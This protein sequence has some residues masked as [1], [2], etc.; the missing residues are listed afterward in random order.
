ML[1]NIQNK[2]WTGEIHPS[3]N[4]DHITSYK[5]LV[6]GY[7]WRRKLEKIIYNFILYDWI[8]YFFF[9]YKTKS[10]SLMNGS[11]YDFEYFLSTKMCIFFIFFWGNQPKCVYRL[12]NTFFNVRS[13]VSLSKFKVLIVNNHGPFGYLILYELDVET[14]ATNSTEPNQN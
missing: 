13:R 9:R 8:K 7:S 11:L 5:K 3:Y 6:A 10:I 14:G 12:G 4:F 2:K 1:I